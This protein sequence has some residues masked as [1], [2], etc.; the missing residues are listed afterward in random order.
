MDYVP[1]RDQHGECIHLMIFVAIVWSNEPICFGNPQCLKTNDYFT[2]VMLSSC[3]SANLPFIVWLCSVGENLATSFERLNQHIYNITWHQCP[4]EIQKCISLM[5]MTSQRPVYFQGYFSLNYSHE[6]FQRVSFN[7]FG[8]FSF[9][10][11]QPFFELLYSFSLSTWDT[12]I[13]WCCNA[14]IKFNWDLWS[15]FLL[16]I[17]PGPYCSTL[18]IDEQI[19]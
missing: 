5:L 19:Q 17:L 18:F 2:L 7:L 10:K 4:V 14:W 1:V 11:V 8:I 9:P 13:L 12:R 6:T 3:A 15:N 16:D